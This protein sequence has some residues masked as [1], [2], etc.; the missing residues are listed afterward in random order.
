MGYPPHPQSVQSLNF[1]IKKIRSDFPIYNYAFRCFYTTFKTD[2]K[3][4]KVE[5]YGDPSMQIPLIDPNFVRI[6]ALTYTERG[7]NFFLYI[8]DHEKTL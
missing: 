4:L 8:G 1:A 3:A 6:T 5:A 2:W 7:G